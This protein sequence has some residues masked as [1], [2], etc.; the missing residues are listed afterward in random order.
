LLSL[1]AVVVN[2][3]TVHIFGYV[4]KMMTDQPSQ[5]LVMEWQ[6]PAPDNYATIAFYLSILILMTALAYAR[7]K[8]RPTDL[9]MILAFTWLAWNGLRYVIWYAM[10]VMPVLALALKELV[11]ER[12]WLATPP[13]NSLN[14]ALAVFLF[15]PVLL[16]QPWFIERL[17]LPE[18]YQEKVIMGTSEGPLLSIHTPVGAAAYLKQNPGGNLFNE[19]GYGS[20]LIWAVPEQGVFVDPR[21]ELY[22]Y[23]QWL[24][25]IRIANGV[26]YNQLLEGYGADRMILDVEYQAELLAVLPDDPLWELEYEDTTTQIWRKRH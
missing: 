23:E 1:A 11:G 12:R 3:Q 15:L 22:P 24:D 4:K 6:T 16:L 2:P 19:M 13:R 14:L 7:L 20:Y 25:Y 8:L 10:V 18:T 17:P 26:H 21:V 5:R 9:F